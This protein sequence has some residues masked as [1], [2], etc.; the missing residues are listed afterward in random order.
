M[1]N[2]SIITQTALKHNDASIIRGGRE[3]PFS[4]ENE[5]GDDGKT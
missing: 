4:E 5:M 1:S 3:E 2:E